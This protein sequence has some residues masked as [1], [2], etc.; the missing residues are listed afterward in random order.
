M[1]IR[2]LPVEVID[3]LV[4]NP[5]CRPAGT[6]AD[7]VDALTKFDLNRALQEAFKSSNV[8]FAE[9]LVLAHGR[10]AASINHGDPKHVL[11]SSVLNSALAAKLPRR[12][13]DYIRLCTA[14]ARCESALARILGISDAA[15]RLRHDVWVASFGRSL[16]HALFLERVARDD[17]VLILGETGTGKEAIANSLIAAT[18]G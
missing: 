7:D 12:P 4:E 17:D 11:P 13:A 14:A 16:Y 9:K 1:A 2:H 18:P 10:I 6:W 3:R 8:V 5:Y 15:E